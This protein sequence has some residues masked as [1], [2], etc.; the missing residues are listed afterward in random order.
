MAVYYRVDNYGGDIYHKSE[1]CAGDHYT[2]IDEDEARESE[3]RPCKNCL[4]A[5]SM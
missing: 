4:P 5:A 2:A 1:T 3:S